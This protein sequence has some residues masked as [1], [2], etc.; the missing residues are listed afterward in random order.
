MPRPLTAALSTGLVA[1]AFSTIVPVAVWP[2]EAKLTAPLFCPPGTVEPMVVSDTWH[3]SEGTSTNYT[4]YCVG[5]HGTLTN[6]GFALPMLVLFTAHVLVITGIV[7]LAA[8][9]SRARRGP[10]DAL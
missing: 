7:L 9:I 1:G 4:L 6:E 10:V 8:L 5:E 3:D 2:G